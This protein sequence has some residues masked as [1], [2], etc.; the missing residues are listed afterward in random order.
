M[1]SFQPPPTWANPVLTEKDPKT[2]ENKATFNPVWLKWFVDLTE[3]LSASP[4]GG[5][6][7]SLGYVVGPT[8]AVNNDIV[9]YDG[10]TGGLIKDSGIPIWNFADLETPTGLVDGINTIFTL[11]NTPNPLASLQMFLSNGAGVSQVFLQIADFTVAGTTV[12]F[13]APPAPAGAA[14]RAFYRY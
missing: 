3:L 7:G 4:T 12:T 13:V 14:L 2:G 8:T 10:T 6:G 9:L 11:T 1:A 5:G